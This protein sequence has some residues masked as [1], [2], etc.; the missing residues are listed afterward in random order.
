MTQNFVIKK[1]GQEF[2]TQ[3]SCQEAGCTAHAEGWLTV[4]NVEGDPQHAGI[5]TWI[6]RSSGR[7]FYE[8]SGTQAMDEA[9]RLQAQGALRVTPELTDCLEALTPGMVVFYFHA[10]QQCFR[11][12]LDREVKFL[13]ATRLGAREHVRPL[14]WNEHMNEESYK[15]NRARELG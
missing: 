12:H 11:Q 13:H 3:M 15:I 6:K 5:A 7:K 2:S 9:H 14:D 10:G 8:W 1:L 4:L